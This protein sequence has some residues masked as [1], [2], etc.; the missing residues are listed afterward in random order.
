VAG[1]FLLPCSFF[2]W[3]G[4]TGYIPLWALLR[5]A[6]P[7]PL[8]SSHFSAT[9]RPGPPFDPPKVDVE[10]ELVLADPNDAVWTPGGVMGP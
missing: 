10:E 5:S 2:L 9:G 4:G 1:G 3:N 6:A 8:L 7:A